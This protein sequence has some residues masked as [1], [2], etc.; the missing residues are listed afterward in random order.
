M[1]LDMDSAGAIYGR[2]ARPIGAIGGM[3]VELDQG[4]RE[5]RALL[6]DLQHEL[7]GAV[8]HRWVE[9]LG[10]GRRVAAWG[11][12]Y[13]GHIVNP[14]HHRNGR[15]SDI[16]PATAHNPE[17]GEKDGRTVLRAKQPDISCDAIYPYMMPVCPDAK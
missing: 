14:A 2:G 10:G 6:I 1:S 17:T 5:L 8:A 11:L 3:A 7:K 12:I 15:S 4:N 13:L 9:R 16:V